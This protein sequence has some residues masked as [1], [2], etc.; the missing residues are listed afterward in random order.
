MNL[1][2]ITRKI[3]RYKLLTL[4]VVIVTICG[5]AYV[6]V[7]KK[8]VYEAKSS[9]AL[10]APPAP[11]GAADI[12]RDPA[13]GRI[14][15]DNP[16]TRFGDQQ[17]I[18]EVLANTISDPAARRAL[19]RAGADPR[20]TVKPSSDFGLTSTVAQVT[21][22]G[23][24]PEAAIKSARIVDNAITGE[25]DRMQAAKG[26]DSDYR[27]K[28]LQVVPPDHAQLSA[29]G[30]LRTLVGVLVLGAVLMFIVIS[31][32]DAFATIRLEQTGHA[33]EGS[34]DKL[35]PAPAAQPSYEQWRRDPAAPP[36]ADVETVRAANA[37]G[38]LPHAPFKS[39][40]RWDDPNPS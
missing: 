8:P 12:A 38:D 13:L 23:W 22:A 7:V 4:P 33:A 29:S 6:A 3:W 39:S 16:Y 34:P 11:P 15:S 21:A 19:V 26:V 14:K 40:S 32:A 17:V 5:A 35:W 36:V 30:K 37:G 24:S 31:V 25:L 18:I 1:L 2:S 28:A 10:L 20:Y 27:I 9:F